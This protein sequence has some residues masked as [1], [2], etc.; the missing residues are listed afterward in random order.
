MKPRSVAEAHA[1]FIGD[2]RGVDHRVGAGVDEDGR[3]GEHLVGTQH[4]DE[5]WLGGVRELAGVAVGADGG[6][7]E[8]VVG[9]A[10]VVDVVAVAGL[11]D[12]EGL[13][14]AVDR[15]RIGHQGDLD[16]QA[17]RADVDRAIGGCPTELAVVGGAGGDYLVELGAVGRVAVEIDADARLVGIPVRIPADRAGLVAL[18]VGVEVGEPQGEVGARGGGLGAFGRGVAVRA[19]V[20]RDESASRGQTRR[21]GSCRWA[22]PPWREASKRNFTLRAPVGMFLRPPIS[23]HRSEVLGRRRGAERRSRC[24]WRRGK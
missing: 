21:R 17:V 22:C 7:G 6:G 2:H 4:V 11:G 13:G 20:R 8:F 1:G 12:D 10:G 15:G 9:V 5:V 23:S 14:R 16:A 18:P 24:R 3:A 19:L